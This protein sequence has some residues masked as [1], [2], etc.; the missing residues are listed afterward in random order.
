MGTRFINN[1]LTCPKVA[2]FHSSPTLVQI[3]GRHCQHT[4][5]WR[6]VLRDM[7]FVLARLKPGDLIININHMD[8]QQLAGWVLGHPMILSNYCEVKDVLLLTVKRFQN[9]QRACKEMKQAWDVRRDFVRVCVRMCV[10][11][12]TVCVCVGGVVRASFT[13]PFT[14]DNYRMKACYQVPFSRVV[15][16]Q[17]MW[18]VNVK[19]CRVRAKSELISSTHTALPT[20]VLPPPLL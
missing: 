10:C 2:L 15:W 14:H 20:W 8:T 3:R 13:E 11:V 7:G 1:R 5:S 19:S 9:R 12:R 6:L 16:S 18:K 4:S 17:A